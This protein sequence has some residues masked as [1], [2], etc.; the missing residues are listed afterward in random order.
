MKDVYVSDLPKFE[1]QPIISYFAVTLKQL[2]SRKDGGQ[3]LALALGDR[4]GQIESRMWENFN[5]TLS[6]FDQGD[7]VKV[8]AEV[9]RY[10]GRLQLNLE[11]IR[12]AIAEEI[13]LADY[14]PQSQFD[15]DEL[16]GKLNAT[17]ESFTNPHLKALLRSFLEDE[18]IAKALRQAPAAK[19]LHHA[20]LGGLLEHI[21]SLTGICDSTA[22]HYPEINRDLLL[23]GAILHDIGKLEELSWGTNFDYTLSGQMLGHI[24][25][26]IAMI[27]KKLAVFVDFPPELRILVEHL[28]LSHHGKLEF[29]SPKL[30]MIPEAVVLHYLD[31]LDAK[32]HTMRTEFARHEAQGRSAGEMTEW[33]RAMDRPLLQS[34]AFLK[35][36]LEPE[37]KE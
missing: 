29:G 12:R 5:G 16:W 24:T 31:D 1:N 36:A 7:I 9:C 6:D 22:K 27:E 35:P 3:Y 32:M 13:V 23:T 2:R 33:V 14:L 10:N 26:G 21:V 8:K 11:K 25:L 18:E 4:T 28:V 20:W 15:I 34:A 19:S 30:P 17:V 37:S